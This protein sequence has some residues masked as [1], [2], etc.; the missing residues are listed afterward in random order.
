MSVEKM[1]QRKAMKDNIKN[2]WYSAMSPLASLIEKVSSNNYEKRVKL[3]EEITDE[4]LMKRFAKHT[5]EYLIRNP[6]H[7]SERFV[8]FNNKSNSM[9][10]EFHERILY[11][12]RNVRSKDKIL[13]DWYLHNDK[14]KLFYKEDSEEMINYEKKLNKLLKL[15]LEKLG[16]QAEYE[17][18]SGENF[19]KGYPDLYDKWLKDI[20]YEKTL[21]VKV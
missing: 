3:C 6:H 10:I 16:A 2:V 14:A 21:I 1:K 5:V 19:S 7:E 18:H 13:S 4:E 12:L 15:E 17:V 9:Y 8:M 11:G 20:G